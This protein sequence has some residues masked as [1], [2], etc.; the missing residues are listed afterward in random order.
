MGG[1]DSFA[2][3]NELE[4]PFTGEGFRKWTDGLRDVE[5]LVDDPQ[6]RSQAAQIRDRAREMKREMTRHSKPPEWSLIQKMIA[7]PLNEL[8]QNVAE[9]LMRRSAERNAV[10]PLDRDPVP[11]QFSNQ[12]QRYYENLG[13]GQ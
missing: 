9:E 13:T 2:G 3:G 12:V 7:E 4:G 11:P 8:R 10:V 6:L 5:E 1:I